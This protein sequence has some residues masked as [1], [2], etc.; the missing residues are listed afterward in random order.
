MEFQSSIEIQ[1]PLE[2]VFEYLRH[3]ENH[4]EFVKENVKSE[5]L[6]E[7][8]MQ[9]GSHVRNHAQFLGF[10]LIEDFVITEFVENK[11][12]AKSSLPSSTVQTSDR[13]EVESTPQGTRVHLL[14]TGEPK[15]FFRL[16]FYA[17]RPIMKR[18]F[19]RILEDLKQVLEKSQ[20]V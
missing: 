6:S 1:R 4:Q 8:P 15:G 16:L 7:G 12:I 13:L 9:V 17:T 18:S 5:Q 20:H 3:Q 11:V 2:Y 19:D 10:K 14:V